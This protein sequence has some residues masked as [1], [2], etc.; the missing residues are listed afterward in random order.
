MSDDYLRSK[1]YVLKLTGGNYYVG[2]CN[3]F[4]KRVKRHI[5]GNGSLWTKLHR[6]VA[7]DTFFWGEDEEEKSVT[8]HY[9]EKYGINKVRG[10]DFAKGGDYDEDQVQW[11]IDND[12]DDIISIDEIEVCTSLKPMKLEKSFKWK[13]NREKDLII[14]PYF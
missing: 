8:L 12:V 6:P 2:K 1:I 3:D 13:I 5:E 9:M 7:T 4:P 14:D 10:W 11:V